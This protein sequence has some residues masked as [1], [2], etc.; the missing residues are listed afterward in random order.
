VLPSVSSLKALRELAKKSH[1]SRTLIG[2]GNPLLDGP[3]TGYAKWASAARTKQSCPTASELRLAALTS[4]RRGLLPISVQGGLVDVAQ[5]R[6][7]AAT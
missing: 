1:A 3:N 7:G 6:L 2:F 5:I 4:E